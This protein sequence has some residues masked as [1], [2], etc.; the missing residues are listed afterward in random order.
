M[1]HWHEMKT[2]TIES[3]QKKCVS[4]PTPLRFISV[5]ACCHKDQN[6]LVLHKTYVL[7]IYSSDNTG[8]DTCLHYLG[9]AFLLRVPV[10]IALEGIAHLIVTH[11]HTSVFSWYILS[12]LFH[13][14]PPLLQ[15][16]SLSPSMPLLLISL[17]LW[18]SF[19]SMT[20]RHAH[21]LM[22]GWGG[23]RGQHFNRGLAG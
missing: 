19:W 23:K 18:L 21:M 14:A 11:T 6:V 20:S 13:S 22:L 1:L 4:A 9:A 15:P 12:L 10:K 16:L 3:S 2:P 7:H 17:F 5:F 8:S